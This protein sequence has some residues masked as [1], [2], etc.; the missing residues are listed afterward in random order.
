MSKEKRSDKIWEFYVIRSQGYVHET[1][2][3]RLHL[4]H[5]IRWWYITIKPIFIIEITYTTITWILNW[6]LQSHNFL[7]QSISSFIPIP[8]LSSVI[9]CLDLFLNNMES[10][11]F[12]THTLAVDGFFDGM[13][14]FQKKSWNKQWLLWPEYLKD[15]LK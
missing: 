11:Y 8:W 13:C 6:L 10:I 15:L 7:Y 12:P 9:R 5:L 4:L 2:S 3:Q 14:N 1:K